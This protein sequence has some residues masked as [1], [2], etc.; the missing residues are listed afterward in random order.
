MIQ[1]LLNNNS[2]SFDLKNKCYACNMSGHCVQQ[3]NKI[4]F[5]PDKE[6]IIKKNEFSFPQVRQAFTRK[7][8]KKKKWAYSKQ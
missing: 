2:N 7:N 6:K 1:D 8:T 4:H 3:C 5:C